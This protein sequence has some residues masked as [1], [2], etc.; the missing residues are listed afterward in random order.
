MPIN[1]SSANLHI[2]DAMIMFYKHKLTVQEG[3][4]LISSE[5]ML[6]TGIQQA[7]FKTP[8]VSTAT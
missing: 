2:S 5:S 7:A 1:R 4:G 8:M 3:G 6:S